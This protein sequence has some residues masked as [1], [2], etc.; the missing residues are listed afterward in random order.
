VVGA[1]D[2]GPEG[3]D[4]A[5]AAEIERERDRARGRAHAG[6]AALWARV[7]L[8]RRRLDRHD[9]W[10]ALIVLAGLVLR[11][12]H[13]LANQ[14][15]RV[16][17]DGSTYVVSA[18]LLAHGHGFVSAGL[19]GMSRGQI[20]IPA[21]EHPPAWTMVLAPVA[22]LGAKRILY[23]QLA[24]ALIGTAT[25]GVVGLTG[26]RIAGVRAGLIAAAIAALYPNLWMY[27]RTVACETLGLLLTA[28][29]V[30]VAYG[31]WQR[32][33]RSAVIALGLLVGALALTRP[34][35]VLLLP[36]LLAPL[37][38]F[39]RTID[40]ATQL[41]WLALG[42]AM[43][44]LTIVP[45]ATYNT[46]RFHQP[47]I[48]TTNLGPTLASSSCDA[49]FYGKQTGL[50]S[51]RCLTEATGKAIAATHQ[52][53]TAEIDVELRHTAL[54]YMRHHLRR[55]PVVVLAR[56]GRAW[57]LYQP[58]DQLLADSIGGAQRDVERIGLYAYWPLAVAA[59][60]GAVVLRRR[61]VPLTP[62]LATVGTVVIAVSSTIGQTRYRALAEP[63]LVLLAA[64]ALDALARRRPRWRA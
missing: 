4:D 39:T 58:Y 5:G 49:T 33:R 23:F 32:P 55:L 24:A 54:D 48:L 22:L 29:I 61:R 14:D 6:A 31:Y 64:V 18:E 37:L 60:A 30:F 57:G 28:L 7:R 19:F 50:W 41:R 25:V 2:A 13:V 9:A 43:T 35:T 40:R 3:T 10:L 47:V 15:V 42:A 59:I 12:W 26:R 63:V 34:E 56:E 16:T 20:S 44:A 38:L 11:V 8:G 46:A 53:D 1:D 45:W 27:E 17:G 52:G 21:A 62:M 51:Y 36:L